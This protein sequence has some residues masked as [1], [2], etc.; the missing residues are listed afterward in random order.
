MFSFSCLLSTLVI[1]I[2]NLSNQLLGYLLVLK[3]FNWILWRISL[4]HYELSILSSRTCTF[5][6]LVNP[7]HQEITA[8]Q[9]F[10]N[11]LLQI[12][13]IHINFSWKKI[14]I[15]TSLIFFF[16][17]LTLIFLPRHLWYICMVISF[18]LKPQFLV[19]I[20]ITFIVNLILL[21]QN[22]SLHLHILNHFRTFGLFTLLS[23]KWYHNIFNYF[24][25]FSMIYK[26]TI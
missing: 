5:L 14:L 16:F 3:L 9:T 12:Y 15:G 21:L 19:F 8:Q 23:L 7:I 24:W 10:H 2:L 17:L 4:L 22:F 26:L 6:G 25:F 13:L 1:F 18:T 11:T 20:I